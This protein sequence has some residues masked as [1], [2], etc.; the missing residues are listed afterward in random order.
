MQQITTK[1]N[2][3]K[4]INP[5]YIQQ[6]QINKLRTKSNIQQ[7]IINCLVIAQLITVVYMIADNINFNRAMSYP[8]L[9]TLSIEELEVIGE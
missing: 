2:T 8:P 1:P 5:L 6:K 9:E 4:T 7:F 3:I